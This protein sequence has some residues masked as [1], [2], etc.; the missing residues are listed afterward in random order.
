M[1]TPSLFGRLLL[2]RRRLKIGPKLSI[3]FGILIALML[4]GYG[5]GISAN[6]QATREI[7][8][9]TSLRAPTTL[10]SA[11]ARANLLRL[12]ADLQAYLALGDSQYREDY[13]AYQAEFETNL[14]E[15]QA[16]VD[17]LRR[18]PALRML[19]VEASPL[20]NTIIVNSSTMIKTQ[21]LSEPTPQNIELMGSMAGFQSSF[22]AMV[23]GLRGYV[24]TRRDSFKFESQAN[25]D[26]NAQAWEL[27][28][29]KRDLLVRSQLASLGRIQEARAAFLVMPE[30]MFEA[31][32]GEHARED[33]YLFRTDAVPLADAMLDLLDRETT[34]QQ[35]LLQ[36][37]LNHG[38]QQLGSAQ[39]TSI[40]G[41][42]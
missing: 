3:G 36:A 19:I 28:A 33:L 31:V 11:Q 34:L 13:A 30:S 16:I 15:L 2:L 29:G 40:G 42:L 4:V 32:E 9:T 24:T 21:E 1:K 39:I 26:S 37:D 17:Q 6:S 10:A 12:V 27:L 8:R 14:A 18:E 25:L 35:D 38:R 22:Y 20:I 7:D 5:L 23:S 41:A